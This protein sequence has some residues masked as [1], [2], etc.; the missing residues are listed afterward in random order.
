MESA[1]AVQDH[2]LNRGRRRM[3]YG[4]AEQMSPE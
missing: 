2:V 1:F 3:G 4:I